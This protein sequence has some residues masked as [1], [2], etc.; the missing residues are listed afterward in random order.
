MKLIPQL[1]TSEN[2]ESLEWPDTPDGQSARD[3]LLPMMGGPQK[4]IKNVHN[5]RVMIAKVGAV[6]VPITITDFH[7]ENCYTV[8]PYSHY[9]SYG[10]LEEVRHLNSPALESVI[11]LIVNPL[12]CYLR[13]SQFDKVVFVNNYLLSTN[14]YP[15]LSGEQLAALTEVLPLWF[16]DRVIVFR[17]LDERKNPQITEALTKLGYDL[18]LSRQVWYIDPTQAVQ[19]Q[20]YKVDRRVLRHHQYQVVKGQNLSDEDLRAA[21]KLYNQLYLEKYSSYNP[22]FT[23]EFLKLARDKGVLHLLALKRGGQMDAVMG[24]VIRD[25]VMTQP[26]FGYDTSA[27]QKSGLYRLLIQITLQEGIQRHLLVHA[28]S[29]VGK[30]KKLRGGRSVI[31]FNAVFAKHLPVSRQR[32]WQLLRVISKYAIPYFQKMDF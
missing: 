14:L 2:I 32:P 7:P 23:F 27:P 21:L 10:A 17:S 8:S 4:Y 1:F 12:A 3:Y 25:G 13:R 28:S 11:K 31:E 9:V 6:I 29:G 20:Q 24:F 18:V 30:F 16:P 5:T 22:Q 19:T 15:P 26:L